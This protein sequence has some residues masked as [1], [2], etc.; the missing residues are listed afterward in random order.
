MD[1][2]QGK[3][4]LQQKENLRFSAN[5]DGLYGAE[6]K[7]MT[8]KIVDHGCKRCGTCPVGYPESNDGKQSDGLNGRPRLETPRGVHVAA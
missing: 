4:C 5:I 1:P 3:N 6:V 7:A 2:Q 8:E